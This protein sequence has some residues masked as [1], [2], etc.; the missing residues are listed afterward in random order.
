MNSLFDKLPDN[1]LIEILKCNPH[2]MSVIFQK[3]MHDI[4]LNN[5]NHGWLEQEYKWFNKSYRKNVF[6]YNIIHKQIYIYEN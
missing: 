3:S 4:I 1:I 5:D 6:W 2:P